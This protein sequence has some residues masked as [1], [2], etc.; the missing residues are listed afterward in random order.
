[1]NSTLAPP[2][3]LSDSVLR[4][5][6]IERGYELIQG[7]LVEMPDM[8]N[9][10]MSVADNILESLRPFV[11]KHRLGRIGR[12]WILRLRP[13][14]PRT[15]RPDVAF[16][17]FVRW[18][19]ERGMPESDPWDVVP[20]LA[21]EVVSHTNTADDVAARIDAYFEAGSSLVWVVYPR[22]FLVYVYTSRTH[23]RI[24]TT[25]DE[26]NGDDLFPGFRMPVLRVFEDVPLGT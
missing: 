12:E 17:S 6:D 20:D 11:R 8:S 25:E 14:A 26:L 15:W 23:A 16:V 24:L 2:V 5:G 1:M 22:N 7:R 18:P 4:N 19:A 3:S 9:R 10:D 13:D 21:V